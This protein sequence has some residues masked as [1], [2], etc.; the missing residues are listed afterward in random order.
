M[1]K[2]TL[3]DKQKQELKKISQKPPR[4]GVYPS[5]IIKDKT[6]YTRKNKHKNKE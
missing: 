1:K 2:I 5:K 4:A 3:S 6:K